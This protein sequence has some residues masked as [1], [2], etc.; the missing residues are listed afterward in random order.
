M[1][2]DERKKLIGHIRQSVSRLNSQLA[3]LPENLE[4]EVSLE[5]APKTYHAFHMPPAIVTARR[6]RI[7]LKITETRVL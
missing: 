2:F 1:K 6:R 7:D 5:D 3:K 4:V